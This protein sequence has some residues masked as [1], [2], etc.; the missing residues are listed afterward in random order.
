[1]MVMIVLRWL[2]GEDILIESVVDGI[3][4][5]MVGIMRKFMLRRWCW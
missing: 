1:M 5:N 2:V 3:D 4:G